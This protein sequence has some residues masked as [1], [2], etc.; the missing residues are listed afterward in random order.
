M[1]LLPE[2]EPCAIGKSDE[3]MAVGKGYFLKARPHRPGFAAR[4]GAT[5]PHCG[6]AISPEGEPRSEGKRGVPKAVGKRDFLK[7]RPHRPPP[8]TAGKRE[9]AI[10]TGLTTGHSFETT[11]P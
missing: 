11:T 4:P 5:S 9:E 8:R 1:G 3:P 2:E 7:A 10:H 6:E